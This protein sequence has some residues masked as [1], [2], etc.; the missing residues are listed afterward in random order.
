MALRQNV[1]VTDSTGGSGEK[2]RPNGRAGHSIEFPGVLDAGGCK[3]FDMTITATGL[4]E[5]NAARVGAS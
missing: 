4:T 2:K 1:G 3:M 5:S